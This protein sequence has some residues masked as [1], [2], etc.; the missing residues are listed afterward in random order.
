MAGGSIENLITQ[1]DALMRQ[2]VDEAEHSAVDTFKT[3]DPS[4]YG[5]IRYH[6]GWVDERFSQVHADPGKRIRPAVCLLSTGAAGGNP[7]QAVPVAAGIELLHNFTLMHDDVQDRSALR[8]GRP[9]VWQLWGEAQ[10]INAGDATFALSQL[11]VLRA[12]DRGMSPET[13][14]GIVEAFNRMTLKIVEGQ[15]L[16]LGFEQR[17]T[18]SA[19]DY[20]RMISGKTAA[21][22][23]F[24]TWA[25]ARVADCSATTCERF[26]EFGQA[27]GL[28]FQ[29]RDD[30]LGIWGE[31]SE[32]GKQS[33]D[34][35]RGRKQSI[36]I[37]MLLEAVS[38]RQRDE[39]QRIYRQPEITDD[40]VDTVREMLDEYG[41]SS[42]LQK[43]TTTYH[44]QALS[45]IEQ[46][47]EE[48]PERR[49]LV[50]LCERL[51]D[52]DR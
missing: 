2:V 27:L 46:I 52:R 38:D 45:L 5:M 15:V 49:A 31:D 43:L 21:I 9:T 6:L 16:D 33:G 8:R 29:V 40:N 48:S 28:G 11:A 51:V 19:D 24:A 1:T 47:A 12:V 13:L 35:I 3:N 10:A 34:D 23:A 18:V 36:P 30:F 25:G 50:E 7:E 20:L 4:L 44:D 32:T 41:V 42:R 37:I 22:V 17:S 26:H 39:L 14:S